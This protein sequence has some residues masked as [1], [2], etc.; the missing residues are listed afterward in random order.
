MIYNAKSDSKSSWTTTGQ[1][2]QIA[3][4]SQGTLLLRSY[5]PANDPTN[6]TL[7]ASYGNLVMWQAG[8]PK[9]SPTVTQ[10]VV[11]MVGGACVVLSGTVYAPGGEIDFGGSSCGVGGGGDAVAT[12]Q[13]VCWD[14][15]LAGNNNFYFAYQRNA[16]ARPYSYGLIK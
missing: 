9:P 5:N 2:D 3:N 11:S 15:T 6:G 10:P 4:G 7:F 12:L 8:E 13:F 14:L 16:F 1:S